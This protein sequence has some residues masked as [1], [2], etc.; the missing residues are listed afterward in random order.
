[1]IGSH[2]VKPKRVK[3]PLK[4]MKLLSRLKKLG[5]L[6]HIF[7]CITFFDLETRKSF[8]A[9][10][11]LK[12]LFVGSSR[13]LGVC[14]RLHGH[15]LVLHAFFLAPNFFHLWRSPRAAQAPRLCRL[16]SWHEGGELVAKSVCERF[17]K[18]SFFF[19]FFCFSS[20]SCRSD[21]RP[22][23]EACSVCGGVNACE[24]Y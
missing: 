17:S 16:L 2:E 7:V 5:F 18:N 21:D 6:H 24:D 14:A 12:S 10:E 11:V 4:Y 13:P 9:S 22:Q 3:T 19:P 23:N 8:L 20:S 15:A 1:M